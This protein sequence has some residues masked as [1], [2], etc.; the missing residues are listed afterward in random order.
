MNMATSG[1]A[2]GTPWDQQSRLQL[3]PKRSM[4]VF[5]YQAPT[6]A[7]CTATVYNAPARIAGNVVGSVTG[8]SAASSIEDGLRRELLY[9]GLT[10]STHYWYSLVCGGGVIMVGD[11]WTTPPGSGTYQFT[12]DDAAAPA[13]TYC[14][15]KPLTTGC[16]SLGSAARQTIPV[17]SNAVIYYQPA[18]GQES[19]LVT[20]N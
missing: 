18:G 1:A 12:R 6:G 19:M 2:A 15:D 10:A 5:R 17:A 11:F 14:T 16:V 8:D 7:A 4:A 20:L 13:L 9:I 3:D